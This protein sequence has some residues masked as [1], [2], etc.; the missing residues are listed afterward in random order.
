MK[1]K[2]SITHK[3]LL[4]LMLLAF[5]ASTAPLYAQ[6]PAP[7][8]SATDV[9]ANYT[10]LEAH[11]TM[12]DGVKLFTSIYMPKDTAQKYPFMMQRTPYSVSPYGAEAYKSSLGPSPL[13]Q[14]EGFIFVYQDARGRWNSEGDFKWMTP[15]KPKK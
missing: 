5:I 13:F 1:F 7:A 12:R 2:P 14:K 15:Y 3:I 8:P 6:T 10:K 11:I 4:S 9:K